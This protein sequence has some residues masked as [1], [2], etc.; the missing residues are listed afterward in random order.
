MSRNSQLA[1]LGAAVV[2]ALVGADLYY[3]RTPGSGAQSQTSDT[4]CYIN[5]GVGS[6]AAVDSQNCRNRSG[7]FLGLRM[8]NMSG[9]PAFLKLYNL[10]TPPICTSANGLQEIIPIPNAGM[11][12]S[13]IVDISSNYFYNTGLGYCLV[14][15]GTAVDNSPPPAGVYGA[16]RTGN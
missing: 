5:K 9:M 2:A 13:G 7:R 14:G 10:A 11:N 8:V 4:P 12:P 6:V 3:V 15:A 16:I 1:V